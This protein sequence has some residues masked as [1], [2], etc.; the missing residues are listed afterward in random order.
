MKKLRISQIYRWHAQ[1]PPSELVEAFNALLAFPTVTPDVRLRLHALG[2]SLQ[3]QIEHVKRTHEQ[4]QTTYMEPGG[5]GEESL[6]LG[7]DEDIR[8]ANQAAFLE[9]FAALL[10]TEVEIQAIPLSA[11][12][13]AS[14]RYWTLLDRGLVNGTKPIDGVIGALMPVIHDDINPQPEP[15]VHANGNTSKP[16]AAAKKAAKRK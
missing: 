9:D 16:Q 10:N 13:K 14:D 15:E 11:L 4:L 6:W 3:K 8:K 2:D 7:E 5:D 12:Q 1:Q